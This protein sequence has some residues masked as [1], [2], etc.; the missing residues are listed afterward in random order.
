MN[1]RNTYK[2]RGILMQHLSEL[3]W[4]GRPRVVST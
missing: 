4:T 1:K 3:T 2:A